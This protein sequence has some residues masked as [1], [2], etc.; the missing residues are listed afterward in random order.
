MC[1]CFCVHMCICMKDLVECNKKHERLEKN[2]LKSKECLSPAGVRDRTGV[3]GWERGGWGEICHWLLI[4]DL[5]S[6]TLKIQMSMRCIV[7][8]V[9][10]GHCETRDHKLIH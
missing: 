2:I 1:V 5:S 3:V 4:I 8:L 6:M 10:T 9:G 7:L